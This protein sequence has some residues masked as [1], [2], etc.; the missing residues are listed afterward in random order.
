M[1]ISE[2]IQGWLL[3]VLIQYSASYLSKAIKQ[4]KEKKKGYR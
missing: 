4:E 1:S 3:F 2:L